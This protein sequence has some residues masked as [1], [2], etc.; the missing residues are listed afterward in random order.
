[1]MIFCS[2]HCSCQVSMVFYDLGSLFF[3]TSSHLGTTGKF[4]RHSLCYTVDQYSFFLP[5]HKA[6]RTFEGNTVIIQNLDTPSDPHAPFLSYLTSRDNIFPLNPELWLTSR[7]SVPTRH[8][9]MCQLR[10][11]L[12]APF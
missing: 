9:F 10:L 4:L 5:S 11:F 8:W 2:S 12:S 7:G 6:D 3:Q 1:M